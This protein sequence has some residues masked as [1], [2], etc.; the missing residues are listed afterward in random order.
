M[1]SEVTKKIGRNSFRYRG[2]V[3]WNSVSN[4]LKSQENITTLKNKMK[5]LKTSI[6]QHSFEKEACVINVLACIIR[7]RILGTFDIVNPF[8][9]FIPF[10]YSSF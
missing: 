5:E 7:I 8:N 4:K 3:L 1:K 10:L 2:G 9:Q 6:K